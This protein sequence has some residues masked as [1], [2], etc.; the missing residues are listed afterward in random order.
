M[1]HFLRMKNID[2]QVITNRTSFFNLRFFQKLFLYSILFIGVFSAH[3]FYGEESA[4]GLQV[5]GVTMAFAAP[6][7][8]SSPKEGAGHQALL[9]INTASAEALLTLPGIGPK[10]AELILKDREANGPFQDANALLRI[11]GIGEKKLEKISPL[12]HF[13]SATP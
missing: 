6:A 8:T 13:E 12:L 11:K 1:K 5:S 2:T 7:D 3:F 9:D 10:L 4:Q